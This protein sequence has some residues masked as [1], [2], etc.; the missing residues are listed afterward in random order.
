M[1]PIKMSKDNHHINNIPLF[2]IIGSPRSGTNMMH[3]F[4]DAHPETLIP[5]EFPFIPLYAPLFQHRKNWT[6]S[7]VDEYLNW[8]QKKI[9]H[10]FWSIK[11]WHTDINILRTRL[12]EQIPDG[13][14][15]ASACRETILQSRS[16]FPKTAPNALILKEPAYALQTKR[17]LQI[18]PDARFIYIHRDPRAQVN[19]LRH[20]PFGSR[21]LTANSFFWNRVQ[22]NLLKLKSSMPDAVLCVA[23]DDL[24]RYTEDSLIKIC[25][26]LCIPFDEKMLHY[27]EYGEALQREYGLN[28]PTIL[29]YGMSSFRSPD[30]ALIDKWKNDLSENDIRIIEAGC[31]RQMKK[32]HYEP[33]Y[34]I[35]F[36]DRLRYIPVHLHMALQDIIGKISLVLPFRWRM[37]ILFAP[38]LFE[39]TYGRWFGKR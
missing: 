16:V 27:H 3:G 37:K 13:L 12:L 25:Q 18:F 20:M 19:S 39:A 26:F 17:L 10:A 6:E 23:Y 32:L 9:K 22:K 11:R 21:L 24:V 31:Y 28:D 4:I 29:M 15:Y 2:F 36:T 35:R 34:S 5:T 38:S 33:L 30:A 8:I 1:E 14:D 7:D